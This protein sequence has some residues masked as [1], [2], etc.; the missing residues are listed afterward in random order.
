MV[1]LLSLFFAVPLDALALL[2]LISS[3]ALPG[4]NAIMTSTNLL[5]VAAERSSAICQDRAIRGKSPP[6]PE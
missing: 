2:P 3:G 6:Y 4:N 5:K 1:M